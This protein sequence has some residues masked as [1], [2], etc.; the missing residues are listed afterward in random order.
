MEKV[1]FLFPENDSAEGNSSFLLKDD[2]LDLSV[3]FVLSTFASSISLNDVLK[4]ASQYFVG[5]YFAD[6]VNRFSRKLDSR[7][8][9][10]ERTA[11]RNRIKHFAEASTEFA[12]VLSKAAVFSQPVQGTD[13]FVR[14]ANGAVNSDDS[15]TCVF[16]G[17]TI[18]KEFVEVTIGNEHLEIG[19]H[20]NDTR[21]LLDWL[22]D[23]HNPARVF[24]PNPKHNREYIRSGGEHVSMLECTEDEAQ[25]FLNRA[26]VC[27]KCLV[28]YDRTRGKHV[29]FRMHR[30]N[31]FHGFHSEDE[32]VENSV[33]KLL[34]TYC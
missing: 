12:P 26:F 4:S 2:S 8:Y 9:P 19:W 15:L 23:H 5:Y 10:R 3:S 14:L 29:H 7:A 32:I 22:A 1:V 27:K 17:F 30:A 13:V 11:L 18:S 16:S 28:Y 24:Y 31:Q 25:F 33:E 34:K 6:N 21:K 20:H